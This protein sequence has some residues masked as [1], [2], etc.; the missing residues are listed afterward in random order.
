MMLEVAKKPT[1]MAC[2][3]VEGRFKELRGLNC[4]LQKCQKSLIDYLDSKRNAFPR[5]V[6]ISDDELFSIL[7]NCDPSSVQKHV[8]KVRVILGKVTHRNMWFL[9]QF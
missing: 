8:I 6:F 7:G 3:G 9:K 5:F 1:V 2:C 4:C